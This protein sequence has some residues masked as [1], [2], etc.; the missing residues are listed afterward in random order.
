MRINEVILK[1]LLKE[2]LIA[3]DDLHT[4]AQ[5]VHTGVRS[6]SGSHF[7]QIELQ[8]KFLKISS[9]KNIMM[10]TDRP[11]LF[12]AWQK[13]ALRDPIPRKTVSGHSSTGYRSRPFTLEEGKGAWSLPLFSILAKLALELESTRVKYN[14]LF[15]APL[16]SFWG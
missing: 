15:I 1:M 5:L 13:Q 10:G 14:R 6:P 2:L 7:R 8:L 16:R 12:E 4:E 3:L 9:P 11:S